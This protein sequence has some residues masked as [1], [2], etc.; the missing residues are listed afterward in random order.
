MTE[1]AQIKQIVHQAQTHKKSANL[2]RKNLLDL[3][4]PI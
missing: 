3:H 4:N 1:Q 2:F